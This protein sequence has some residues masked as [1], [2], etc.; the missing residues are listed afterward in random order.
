MSHFLLEDSPVVD[1]EKK[2]KQR[3]AALKKRLNKLPKSNPVV[4][5]VFEEKENDQ[6]GR[7]E[8]W[9]IVDVLVSTANSEF[10]EGDMS[11]GQA[12]KGLA[13]ALLEV[14]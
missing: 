9:D 7:R 10:V 2:R 8:K 6:E 11:F 1:H 12:V 14:K 5:E 13:K 4:K 3:R